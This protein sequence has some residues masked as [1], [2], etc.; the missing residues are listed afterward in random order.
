MKIIAFGNSRYKRVA[1]NWAKYLHKHG[2]ENYTI[3]ALDLETFVYLNDNNINTVKLNDDMFSGNTKEFK[4]ENYRWDMRMKFISHLLENGIDILHSDLDA[5]WL[6]DPTPLLSSTHDIISSTGHFPE[7]VDKKIGYTLCCGW[8]LYRSC[9]PVKQL[10]HDIIQKSGDT[11]FDDQIEINEAIY[12]KSDYRD[13]RVKTLNQNIISRNIPHTKET[14]IS[15]PH[16]K[17]DI[18][19]EEFLKEQQLWCLD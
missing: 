16:S 8:I 5:I 14:Y 11:Y 7:T 1:H 6:K 19:R 15:H 17:K 3:Y 4:P 9:E 18:N 12:L 10:F 2:I 13:I